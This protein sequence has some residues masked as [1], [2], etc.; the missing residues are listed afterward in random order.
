MLP[1]IGGKG[2]KGLGMCGLGWAHSGVRKIGPYPLW[3]K[4]VATVDGDS[5]HVGI[6]RVLFCPLWTGRFGDCGHRAFY[7]VR[8]RLGSFAGVFVTPITG[9]SGQTG[10]FE[11]VATVGKPAFCLVGAVATVDRN[12][13]R[14]RMSHATACVAKEHKEP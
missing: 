4:T 2:G 5:G 8:P 12:R 3:T 1:A 10:H 9:D 13:Y 6:V 11:G 7:H 14:P